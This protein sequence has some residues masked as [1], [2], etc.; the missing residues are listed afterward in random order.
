[1]Q[2]FT[3]AIILF[4]LVFLMSKSS[5]STHL[6]GGEITA[7]QLVD[8]TYEIT[9]TVYRD[10][11]GI[12][13]SQWVQFELLD[14]SGTLITNFNTQYD[15]SISGGAL[16]LY[17]YG[18]EVYIYVDTITLPGPGTYHIS[19][20]RCCRNGAIQNL[21]T[22]LNESMYLTT[23]ITHFGSASN[24]TPFFLVKP[25]IFLPLNTSWAYNPLPFDPNG[26]SLVWSL[27]TPLTAFNQVCAGYTLP[28]GTTSNPFTI[29]SV[30]GSITWT[31]NTLGNFVA[32]VLVEEYRNGVKIGEIRRDMQF[33]VVNPTSNMAMMTNMGSVPKDNNNNYHVHLDVDERYMFSF[34]AEDQDSSDVV[35]MA[36]IGEPFMFAQG[37]RASFFVSKTGKTYGNEIEGTLIWKP[38][39]ALKREKPYIIVYRVSDGNYM[40]DYT[41]LYTVN[42]E[43][44]PNIGIDGINE[45]NKLVIYPNPASNLLNLKVNLD[46]N[47]NVQ[48]E[49]FNVHGKQVFISADKEMVSGNHIMSFPLNLS[50]GNYIVTVK[51]DEGLVSHESLI[52]QE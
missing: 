49:I 6:M 36:A 33:I 13:I 48:V 7:K 28:S 20:K 22:P 38:V 1:M 41:V 50:A 5:F 16:S 21:S 14:S 15:T 34:F 46:V 32:S 3:R 45:S 11:L 24:S 31:A 40:N 29:N 39:Q 51:S 44:N 12:P 26:D 17:P 37:I 42:G 47:S 2:K 27:D 19:Y 23:T 8:S 18:V 35:N 10:T 9:L 4:S 52:I 43:S 25:V 30:T